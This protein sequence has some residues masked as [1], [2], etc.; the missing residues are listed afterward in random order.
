MVPKVDVRP[1]DGVLIFKVLVLQSLYGLSD[2]Q[3][4]YQIKDRLS[5]MRF[6]GLHLCHS[7]PD[8]KTI[9]LYRERLKK[10]GLMDHF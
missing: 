1:N 8:T 3:T 5:F 6:L 9:W 7:V 10:D 2:D 4:E